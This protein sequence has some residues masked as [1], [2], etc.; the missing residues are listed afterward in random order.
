[1]IRKSAM[2]VLLPTNNRTFVDTLADAYEGIGWHVERGMSL[3]ETLESQQRA[4]L[5]H[6]NWPEELVGWDAGLQENLPKVLQ[7]LDKAKGRTPIVATVH[8]IFPHTARDKNIWRVAYSEIYQ[9]VDV[10]H[11]MSFTSKELFLAIFPELNLKKHIISVGFGFDHIDRPVREGVEIWRNKLSLSSDHLGL[12]SFGEL[13]SWNELKLL[14]DGFAR[15]RLNNKRLILA[16]R[17]TGGKGFLQRW[18]HRGLRLSWEVRRDIY[19]IRRYVPDSEVANLFSA[20]DALVVVRLESLNS[21]L[22]VLGMKMGV[23]VIAP[24]VGAIPEHLGDAGNILWDPTGGSGALAAALER[25]K[26]IDRQVVGNA[27]RIRAAGWTGKR[28]IECVIA[29]IR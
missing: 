10:I 3:I 29:A 22:V 9:R 4:T 26:D 28:M 15:A 24:R 19:R 14:K 12:L 2:R 7:W 21:G 1:M 20:V 18:L 17:Y 25:S 5:I 16:S 8:N 27:N 23:P 6:I 11:H 13:R